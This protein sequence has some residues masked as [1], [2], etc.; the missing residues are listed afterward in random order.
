MGRLLEL[1][2]P[3]ITWLPFIHRQWYHGRLF[4]LACPYTSRTY[5]DAVNTLATGKRLNQLLTTG[6]IYV[7]V[8]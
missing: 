5:C 2:A 4:Q 8:R 7:V 6:L 3:K 1:A